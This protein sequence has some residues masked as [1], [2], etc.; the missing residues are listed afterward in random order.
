MNLQPFGP[1]PD[2][3]RS[4]EHYEAHARAA[5]D[6]R[7]HYFTPESLGFFK[8]RVVLAEV[9][10]RGCIFAAIESLPIGGWL[11]SQ[12]R[13]RYRLFNVLGEVLPSPA[14]H[15]KGFEKYATC[16]S[17]M[18]EALRDLDVVAETNDAIRRGSARFG[19]HV[20]KLAEVV[21]ELEADRVAAE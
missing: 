13:Y 4:A 18:H 16:R 21:A 17:H 9:H 14:R 10:H 19:R 20:T 3:G 11:E 6:G 15:E 5:L 12:R 8:A 2:A 7:S 1:I